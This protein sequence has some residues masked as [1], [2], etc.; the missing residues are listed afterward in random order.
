MVAGASGL[1]L[2][3]TQLAR[4]YGAHVVSTAGSPE[5]EAV[6][7]E[8]GAEIVVNHRRQPLHEV[9]AEHPVDVAVDCVGTYIGTCVEKMNIGGR[10]IIVA[11]L[12]GATTELPLAAMYKRN[13]TVTGITLRS[14]PEEMKARILRELETTVWPAIEDGRIRSRIHAVFPMAEVN[15]AH[16]VLRAGANAGKVL[17]TLE[18]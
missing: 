2:A 18:A 3:M 11:A 5:K 9:L 10:W 13:L 7:R 8:F 17:L 16:A 15:A 4:L 6:A 1:G 14:R 12:G